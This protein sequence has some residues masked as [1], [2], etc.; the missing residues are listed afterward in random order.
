MIRTG[1]VSICLLML[2]AATASAA[3]QTCV[4][5]CGT[6]S[7][8][9][10]VHGPDCSGVGHWATMMTLAHLKNAG[11]IDPK[12]VDPAKTKTVRVASEKTGKDLW[13]QV[14]RVTFTT[15]SGDVVDAIAVHDASNEECSM[16]GVD[17]FLISKY[18]PANGS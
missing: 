10:K 1:A 6:P 9:E 14:Y 4:E 5:N 2:A 15:K 18:L 7:P 8:Y 17:V 11:L 3:T 16:S 12:D 13:R